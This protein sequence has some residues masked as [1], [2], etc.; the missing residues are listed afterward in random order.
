MARLFRMHSVKFMREVEIMIG[1][2]YELKRNEKE[3]LEIEKDLA[4]YLSVPFVKCSYDCVNSHKYKD[5]QEVDHRKQE[6][7]ETGFWDMCDFIINYEKYET[8]EDYETND[9]GYDGEVYELLYLKGNGPYIVIT[10]CS[11]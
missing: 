7:K 5:K 10:G 9:G 11:E 6:A 3:L 8:K 1:N 2:K 4:K